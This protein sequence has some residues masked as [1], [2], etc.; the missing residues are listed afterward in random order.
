MSNHRL[1]RLLHLLP[2]S[3]PSLIPIPSFF[4]GGGEYGGREAG[5]SAFSLVLVA[6]PS[7]SFKPSS[8][9]NVSC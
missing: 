2:P 9:I 1:L 5:G 4:H 3:H 8:F 7:S 6:I